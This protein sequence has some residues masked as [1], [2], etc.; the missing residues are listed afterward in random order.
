MPENDRTPRDRDREPANPFA[1][2]EAELSPARPP[3][4]LPG[5]PVGNEPFSASVVIGRS[6]ELYKENFHLVFGT[7]SAWLLINILYQAA[8]ETMK[9]TSDM[10][11]AMGVFAQVAFGLAGVVLQI[12]LTNGQMMV[13]LRVA[14]GEPTHFGELFQGGPYVLRN[15]GALVVYWLAVLAAVAVCLTPVGLILWASPEGGFGPFL[16]TGVLGVLLAA[17]VWVVA[18]VR[19][20]QY[21]YLIIDREAGPVE[22]LKWSYSLTRGYTIELIGLALVGGLLGA[23]GVLL[24]GVGLFVTLPWSMLLSACTYVALTGGVSESVLPKPPHRDFEESR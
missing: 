22:S 10:E 14:R 5:T 13:L 23:S 21:P 16:V 18:A 1:P 19:F 6:W 24:C 2:P 8:G 11:S 15:V 9:A 4:R 17:G 7:V 3:F 12:W 20:Y